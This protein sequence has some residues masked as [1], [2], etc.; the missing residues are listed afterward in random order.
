MKNK[1]EKIKIE[2]FRNITE[3]EINFCESG[4]YYALLGANGVG[5]TTVL[6]AI[7]IAFSTGSSKYTKVVETDFLN[8]EPI[9]F[10]VELEHPY[11]LQFEDR[12]TGHKRLIPCNRFKKTIQY[13][14]R[15]EAL[16]MFSSEYDERVDHLPQEFESDPAIEEL[17]KA[18]REG[19]LLAGDQHIVRSFKIISD[20]SFEY[21]TA[22][23]SLESVVYEH[24]GFKYFSRVLFPLTF[25]FDNNR[26]RELHS[27][28]NTVFA[29]IIEEL[30]WRYKK[31][32]KSQVKSVKE[33][34]I[35]LKNVVSTVDSHKNSLLKGSQQILRNFFNLNEIASSL[36]FYPFD[37]YKPYS[38]SVWGVLSEEERI[39]PATKQGSG[40][41][42]VVSLSLSISFARE[43]KE[44]VI[45]LIDE[46]ELHL[47][48]KIKRELADLLK[49]VGSQVITATH[50][51]QFI[52]RIN[53]QS[54]IILEQK[55]GGSLEVN[56]GNDMSIAD[57]LFR[58]YSES[59]DDL[60][61]PRRVVI[62]EGTNDKKIL[63]KV[64]ELLE[65]NIEKGIHFVSA[66]GKDR[67]PNKP[68]EYEEVIKNLIQTDRWYS[69]CIN[70]A[71]K[72]VVDADVSK[73]TVTGW[74]NT[75]GLDGVTQIK[76]VPSE[77]FATETDIDHDLEMEFIY[78]NGL[79]KELVS[80]A[81]TKLH[82]GTL[83]KDKEVYEIIDIILQDDKKSNPEEKKQVENRL[84]KSMLNE[85]VY[86]NLTKEILQSEEGC[87]LRGL[88]FWISR[89]VQ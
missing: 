68:E 38:Q 30:E 73:S 86:N 36:D 21:E 49:K 83:L 67:I 87:Q 61:I 50:T 82:D 20:D 62:V 66:G 29:N 37:W 32:L 2:N 84:S 75:Y 77:D 54:N 80:D 70:K 85:F 9:V 89:A 4:S 10:T 25:Y 42:N 51:P 39:I 8:L 1:I 78:P 35:E 44:P 13:R 76:R 55:D 74:V 71:I 6:E 48:S 11:F 52:N 41:A 79:V 27:E 26:E 3:L 19:D 64:L 53:Y 12:R 58:I 28:Y 57:L 69:G 31:A 88:G 65:L 72:I 43:T 56:Y 33:K 47:E 40:I 5:K 81:K 14:E 63:V 22:T 16:K 59:F 23:S 60:V 18:L 24:M 45:F 17:Q 46:P 34:T 7:N 15:K